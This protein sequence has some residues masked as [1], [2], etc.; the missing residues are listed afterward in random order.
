MQKS[1]R[2]R[3]WLPPPTA[4][5]VLSGKYASAKDPV[6]SLSELTRNLELRKQQVAQRDLGR[7][8]AEAKRHINTCVKAVAGVLGNTPAVC[9]KAYI[10]PQV[11]EAFG[12][13]LA[14]RPLTA[15]CIRFTFRSAMGSLM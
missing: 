12:E 3:K 13:N 4:K 8:L 15:S 11:L 7:R 10:H 6:S 9:R 14:S 1:P 5:H 2:R